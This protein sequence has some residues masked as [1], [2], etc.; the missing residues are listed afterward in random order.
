MEVKARGWQ[1]VTFLETEP[2]SLTSDDPVPTSD[3]LTDTA[4][5]LCGRVD[6]APEQLYRLVG[7]GLSNFQ[8]DSDSAPQ[9]DDSP[10]LALNGQTPGSLASSARLHSTIR[11]IPG[12]FV[13]DDDK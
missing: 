10:L 2:R 6:L 12:E 9:V 7:V 13:D 1:S 11:R 4:L 3:V 8:L 5:G